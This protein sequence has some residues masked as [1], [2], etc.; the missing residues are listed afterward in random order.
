LLSRSSGSVW[1][2]R[3]VRGSVGA[4]A[5]QQHPSL[6][7][8]AVLGLLCEADT[9][10][11]T[12]VRALAPQGEIGRVWS[13]PRAIV[14]RT[15]GLLIDA[16][17]VE[18]A[19]VEQGARGSTRTLL[20]VTPSGRH[21]FERWLA[22]P[23]AHVRDLRSEL[24]LK[25]LFARR[26]GRDRAPVLQAQRAILAET[27]KGLESRPVGEEPS[28]VTLR[29]FRLETA[30]AGQRFVDQELAGLVDAG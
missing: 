11:W 9:H 14:Y 1:R 22:E 2:F 27:V 3:R 28:E 19:G 4:M 6:G 20:R 7:S 24:L 18:R 25:L 12:L 15:I 30:R 17:L 23:V 21:D 29:T 13:I 16:G 10:G 5:A 26:S 8:W